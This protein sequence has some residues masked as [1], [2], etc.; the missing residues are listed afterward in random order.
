MFIFSIC[1]LFFQRCY[2]ISTAYQFASIPHTTTHK[3]HN[4]RE[5]N[6]IYFWLKANMIF[7]G[8][9]LLRKQ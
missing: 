6:A 9:V 1:R 7:K 2:N 5:N 3:Y 8:G 4:C